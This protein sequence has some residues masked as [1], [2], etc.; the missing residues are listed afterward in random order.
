MNKS[1]G[2]L[3]LLS[4]LCLLMLLVFSWQSGTGQKKVHVRATGSYVSRDMTPE[5]TRQK[6]LD[7]AK[8]D[9]L[10]KAG[11]GESITVSNF[12]YKFEDNEKFREIFQDFTSTETGGEVMIDSILSEE[13]TFNEFDNM[14][15]TVE[16]EATVF[17]HKEEEDPTLDIKVEG[18]EDHYKNNQYLTFIV[19][20]GTNGY[21]KIFNVTE[22]EVSSL[23]F[24]YIDE[25][26]PYL[27]DDPALLLKA[28]QKI[29]FPVN[30]AFSDGYYLDI[31]N[32][33][34]DK[35]FNLLIFVFTRENI[36]FME[37][38]GDM[39]QIMKWIYS[40]PMDKRKV[41]QLGFVINR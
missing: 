24:P 28:F 39:K 25:K 40:I 38:A 13:R 32:P 34:K 7:E 14:V 27:N 35:E 6:A 9:A 2:C 1:N 8:Q 15:I 10:N 5:Q 29:T 36:P 18:I 16:V 12:L 4:K 22:E 31:S 11:V 3:S 19:T 30:Q 23:L 26:Q 41:I 21:L 20:P 33:E 17:I 37:N